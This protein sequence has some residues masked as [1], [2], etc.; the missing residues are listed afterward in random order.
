[1]WKIDPINCQSSEPFLALIGDSRFRNEFLSKAC[2]LDAG[3]D[4]YY[5]TRWKRLENSGEYGFSGFVQR[6][7]TAVEVTDSGGEEQ[8]CSSTLDAESTIR[9]EAKNRLGIAA[10]Q[11]ETPIIRELRIQQSKLDDF[12]DLLDD[13]YGYYIAPC[14]RDQVKSLSDVVAHV[15]RQNQ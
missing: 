14:D 9:M 10:N 1:M 15:K 13:K 7:V 5:D 2:A 12:L 8:P 4:I 11:Y 3:S 6:T